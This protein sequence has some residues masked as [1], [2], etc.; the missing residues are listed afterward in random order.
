MSDESKIL[1]MTN[2]RGSIDAR[3]DKTSLGESPRYWRLATLESR[4]R[5]SIAR[6]GSLTFVTARRSATAARTWTTT[7]AFLLG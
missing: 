4:A 5:L 1:C 2:E 6:P 3:V 7:K